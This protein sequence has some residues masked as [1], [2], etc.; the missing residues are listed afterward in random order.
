MTKKIVHYVAYEGQIRI[1]A[2]ALLY[3]VDHPDTE[4]VSN[5]KLAKTSRVQRHDPDT[6]EIETLN[7]IYRRK[8]Q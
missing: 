8:V 6:D 4:N 5:T 1:G 7:T 2:V 3:P